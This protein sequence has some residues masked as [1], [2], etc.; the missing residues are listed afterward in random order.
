MGNQKKNKSNKMNTRLF[1]VAALLCI[2]ICA[3]APNGISQIT[4]DGK[5][6]RWSEEEQTYLNK[7]GYKMNKLMLEEYA[8]P[9]LGDF[10]EDSGILVLDFKKVLMDNNSKLKD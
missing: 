9:E 10:D 7:K 8:R 5:D 3:S 1:A 2:P 6:F 4:L